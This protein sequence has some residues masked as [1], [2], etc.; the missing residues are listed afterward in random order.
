MKTS[1]G[2]LLAGICAAAFSLIPVMAPAQE[3]KLC[4]IMTED[5]IDPEETVEFEGVKVGM[6][7]A[8]CA[9]LFSKNAK[10]YI[11]AA[12]ELLPQ[13]KG[14]ET[15]LELDKITLLPQKFCPIK[16]KSLVCPD[17]PNADYKGVKVYFFDQRSADKWKTDPDA[18]AKRAVDAGL[19][20][21]LAGKL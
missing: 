12:P 18:N 10:Y 13:F 14:M 16:T 19:L 15:K 20:P 1:N 3:N 8:K 17:S 7:C 2:L 11:K 4:P 21:Q 6:C 9:K 5:E